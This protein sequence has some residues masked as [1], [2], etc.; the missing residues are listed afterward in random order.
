MPNVAGPDEKLERIGTSPDTLKH[1]T[2]PVPNLNFFLS[3]LEKLLAPVCI[4]ASAPVC[5]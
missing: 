1:K 4:E 5:I 3:F 2:N